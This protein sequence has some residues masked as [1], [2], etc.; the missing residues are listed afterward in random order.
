MPRLG[1]DETV[2]PA[3]KTSASAKRV[4]PENFIR[5]RSSPKGGCPP[6]GSNE[7]REDPRERHRALA[8]QARFVLRNVDHR[9]LDTVRRRA[10]VHEQVSRGQIERGLTSCIRRAAAKIG[11][12]R[13]E[14]AASLQQL[15]AELMIGYA[16]TDRAKPGCHA[17]IDKCRATDDNRQWA[18]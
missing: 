11:T 12:R 13:G 7:G 6:A 3:A 10:R 16:Q 1:C 8:N 14:R 15:R 18:G 2:P 5:T 9:R 17:G 4:R